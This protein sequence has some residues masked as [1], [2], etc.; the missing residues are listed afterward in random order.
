MIRRRTAREQVLK[1]LYQMDVSGAG[2]EEAVETNGVRDEYAL[3]LLT[4]IEK[5]RLEVDEEIKPLLKGWKLERLNVI[6]RAILRIGTYELLFE[7]EIP[8]A[9]AVD[10]AVELA[11]KYSD[12]KSRIFINGILSAMLKEKR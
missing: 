6:D 7:E 5:H 4:E 9:V 1:C 8:D 11:K 3:H 12:E 2:I 10:E